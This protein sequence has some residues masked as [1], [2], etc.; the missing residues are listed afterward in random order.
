MR[1][2][3]SALAAAFVVATV[4]VVPVMTAP[5]ASAFT[6]PCPPIV[7]TTC[8]HSPSVPTPNTPGSGTSGMFDGTPAGGN[9]L[10]GRYGYAP[11]HWDTYNLPSFVLNVP[12][13][14]N[15]NLNTLLGGMLFGA[16]VDIVALSSGLSRLLAAD[17]LTK[18]DVAVAQATAALY[19]TIYTEFLPIAFAI[20]GLAVLVKGA[21]RRDFGGA[22]RWAGWSLAVLVA[23]AYVSF[24]STQASSVADHLVNNTTNTEYAAVDSPTAEAT[25]AAATAD[26]VK[27][28]LYPLWLKGEVGSSTSASAIKYGPMLYDANGYDWQQTGGNGTKSPPSAV[29]K[30]KAQEWTA[31]AKGIAST[32]PA[33]AKVM[34][35]AGDG[36]IST[37]IIAVIAAA[38]TSG[39]RLVA[40]VATVAALLEVRLAMILLPSL[41]LVGIFGRF[42]GVLTGLVRRVLNMI[43]KAALLSLGAAINILLVGICLSPKVNMPVW[44]GVVVAGA[45]TYLLWHGFNEVAA[46]LRDSGSGS[47]AGQM[48]TAGWG[49]AG[50]AGGLLFDKRKTQRHNMGLAT[51][52]VAA[53]GAGAA[54]ALVADHVI[55]ER[56]EA[57]SPEPVETRPN[58][59]GL[60]EPEISEPELPEIDDNPLTPSAAEVVAPERVEEPEREVEVA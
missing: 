53:T 47:M 34:T 17:F 20:V 30:A 1:R 6:L 5:T 46:R 12:H 44:L 4:V 41:A 9:T 2:I 50:T 48:G 42:A 32:D 33:A 51:A 52:L 16:A 14:T 37:G 22:V 25:P 57:I 59:S 58:P 60:P 29:T 45:I 8:G 21:I 11:L 27:E 43:A 18:L 35:G 28:I 15:A 7:K 10:Y 40:A 36:R 3:R 38:L 26:E 55:H 13:D 19:R 23:V 54:G 31:A 56:E 24:A 49:A 39:F